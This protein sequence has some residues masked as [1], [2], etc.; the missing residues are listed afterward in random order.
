MMAAKT[1]DINRPEES[2]SLSPYVLMFIVL[3][4]LIAIFF[5]VS[6]ATQFFSILLVGTIKCPLYCIRSFNSYHITLRRR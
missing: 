6:A 1:A 5:F 3:R 4:H 2:T